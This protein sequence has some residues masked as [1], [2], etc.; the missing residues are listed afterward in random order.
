MMQLLV[1]PNYAAFEA[2]MTA[3]AQAQVPEAQLRSIWEQVSA[4][5]GPIGKHS[6][7]RRTS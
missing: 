3:T 7:L 1:A 2:N 4:A 5:I 6:R